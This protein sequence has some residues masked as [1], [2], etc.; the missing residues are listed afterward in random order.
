MANPYRQCP[1]DFLDPAAPRGVS[2]NTY[3]DARAQR[4]SKDGN[5]WLNN[6]KLQAPSNHLFS[7]D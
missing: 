6:R 7:G 2:A 3:Q 1:A 4:Y 5:H